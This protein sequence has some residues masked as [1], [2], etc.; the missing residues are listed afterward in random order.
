MLNVKAN[1][2]PWV[3]TVYDA[4]SQLG[5]GTGHPPVSSLTHLSY[6]NSNSKRDRGEGPRQSHRRFR[7]RNA[8]VLDLRRPRPFVAM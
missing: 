4:P 1:I 8:A 6:S 3:D 2:G 5:V 7:C